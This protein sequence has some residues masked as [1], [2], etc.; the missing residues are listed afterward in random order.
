MDIDDDQTINTVIEGRINVEIKESHAARFAEFG[1]LL[2]KRGYRRAEIAQQRFEPAQISPVI[3]A[4]E[5]LGQ[6][7]KRQGEI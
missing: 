4:G 7:R 5:F 2:I 1:I 3:I 6:S